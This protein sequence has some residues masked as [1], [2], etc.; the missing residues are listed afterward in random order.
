MADE[1][2]GLVLYR[3]L[4][5]GEAALKHEETRCVLDSSREVDYLQHG[6]CIKLV[7]Y[8]Y[9]SDQLDLE[10]TY[11]SSEQRVSRRLCDAFFRL[12]R[13]LPTLLPDSRFCSARIA[14]LT[15]HFG[16]TVEGYLRDNAKIT[17]TRIE[18]QGLSQ[19]KG[20]LQCSF[21]SGVFGCR[22]RTPTRNGSG[23]DVLGL[24]AI[25]NRQ[26]PFHTT[27]DKFEH[28]RECSTESTCFMLPPS[29]RQL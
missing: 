28:P 3:S 24:F 2:M 15:L 27:C 6:T 17:Y 12:P 4:L 18:L 16:L 26:I 19:T 20:R 1:R 8:R 5:R 25:S 7:I 9:V 29:N 13:Y 21:F 11:T 22:A 23:L 14:A 10:R